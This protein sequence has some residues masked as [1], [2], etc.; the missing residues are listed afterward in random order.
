MV[1]NTDKDL[2][3][4][5]GDPPAPPPISDPYWQKEA[6]R[7]CEGKWEWDFPCF[8]GY[9]EMDSG[10][11]TFKNNNIYVSYG[12]DTVDKRSDKRRIKS[13]KLNF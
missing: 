7:Q 12:K 11:I 4:V 10:I 3:K 13:W 9:V 8:D 1:L 5:L 6:L 2:I